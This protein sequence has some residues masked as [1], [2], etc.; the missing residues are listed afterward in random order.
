MKN[1]K[2]TAAAGASTAKPEAQAPVR[3][4]Q[5]VVLSHSFLP[6]SYQHALS[7]PPT[8]P[9]LFTQFFLQFW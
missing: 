2:N 1:K 9:P 8:L 5:A 4:P 6:P 3:A 7:P